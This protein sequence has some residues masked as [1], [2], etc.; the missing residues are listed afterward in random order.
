[1][2]STAAALF[3][4]LVLASAPSARAGSYTITTTPEREAALAAQLAEPTVFTLRGQAPKTAAQYLQDLVEPASRSPQDR[5]RGEGD[6]R[7]DPPRT[8]SMKGDRMRVLIA[9]MLGVLA[10]TGSV[11]AQTLPPPTPQETIFGL[12]KGLGQ[13][14]QANGQLQQANVE[15]EQM[16]FDILKAMPTCQPSPQKSIAQCVADLQAELAKLKPPQAA[17]APPGVPPK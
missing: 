8:H 3:A 9:T 7:A 14:Q 4:L 12:R 15:Q 17:A 10:L 1:M 5:P 13:L 11:A 16:L 6:P 2:R